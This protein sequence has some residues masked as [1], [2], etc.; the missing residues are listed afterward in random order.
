M[1]RNTLLLSLVSTTLQTVRSVPDA[2]L[3]TAPVRI[4]RLARLIVE[5]GLQEEAFAL[6]YGFLDLSR[7][8]DRV[9]LADLAEWL[10]LPPTTMRLMMSELEG[11]RSLAA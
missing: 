5:Q 6:V 2:K 4:D 10:I 9:Y 1:D 7:W 8:Q 3:P 11:S